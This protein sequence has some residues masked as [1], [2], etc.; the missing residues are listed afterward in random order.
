MEEILQAIVLG[1]VQGLTEFLPISSSG[2][3]IVTRELFGWDFSNDLTFDVALHLGTTLAVLTFF[4]REWLMML[5]DGWL[6][7]PSGEA[8]DYARSVYNRR[9]LLLL[10]LGSIPAGAVGFILNDYVEEEVRSPIVVGVMLL[11]FAAALYAAERIGRGERRVGDSGWRDALLIGC[12]QAVSLVPGVSRAG[13][14]IAAGLWRGFTRQEAARFS[15]LLATPVILGAGFLKLSEAAIDGIPRGDI[16]TIFIG[17]ASAAIVGWLAIH[18]LLRMLQRQGY[19]VFVM[20][21]VVAGVFVLL[22]FGL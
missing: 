5:S 4:W 10:A 15:F 20:Y 16:A 14:T 6:G 17:A 3:L 21:R 19:M 1:V 18:Y 2:H 8:G 22:Y 11:V 13:I 7:S 12:A 9:L